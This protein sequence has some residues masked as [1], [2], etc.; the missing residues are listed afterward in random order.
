AFAI[1][2]PL[3]P[4]LANRWTN[5]RALTIGLFLLMLG[6]TVRV[7]SFSIFLFVGT[8]LVGL[9]IAML[10]VLLPGVIKENFPAKVAIMTSLYTTSMSFFATAGSA[11]SVPVVEGLNMGWKWALFIW[12]LPVGL[13]FIVWLFI[14]QK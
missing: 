5:E 7:F 10:N 1:M 14:L 9:G 12:I 2:S 6:I 13:A 11:V 3:V 8:L 4:K